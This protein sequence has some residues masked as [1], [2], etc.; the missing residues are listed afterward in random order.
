LITNYTP[1][2]GDRNS[3]SVDLQLVAL[4]VLPCTGNVISTMHVTFD[5]FVAVAEQDKNNLALTLQ[6]N[7]AHSNVAVTIT[8]N[9]NLQAQLTLTDI[10]GKLVYSENLVTG[11]DVVRN[12]D[13]SN[14]PKG[15][16]IV[17]LKTE[18]QVKT[19]RLIVQ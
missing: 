1:G 16:Y 14:Y 10:S 7:P 2:N 17:Q 5:E 4:P 12:I 9:K 6:P 11:K 8:G 3:G 15:V 18:D 19:E 13:L